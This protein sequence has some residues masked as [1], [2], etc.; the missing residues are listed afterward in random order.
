MVVEWR[1]FVFY[2]DNFY[3]ESIWNLK[4][5]NLNWKVFLEG[6][7]R[8]MMRTKNLPGLY[9][10]GQTKIPNSSGVTLGRSIGFFILLYCIDAVHIAMGERWAGGGWR[11]MTICKLN[12]IRFNVLDVQRMAKQCNSISTG[13]ASVCLFYILRTYCVGLASENGQKINKN[14]CMGEG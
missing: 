9:G 2:I 7:F 4:S 5:F 14:I 1:I 13:L 12:R 3:A 8:P 6:A 11:P 10:G